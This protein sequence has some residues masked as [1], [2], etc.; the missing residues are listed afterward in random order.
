MTTG[1]KFHVSSFSMHSG[2][3]RYACDFYDLVLSSRGYER[4]DVSSGETSGIELIRPYDTV[5]IE[6][7][8]NQDAE[9]RFLYEL[10][11]RRHQFIDL[12]LHD[13]PFIRWPHFGFKN[14]LL[15]RLSKF[16][17]LYLANFGF[18]QQ[19][20]HRIRRIFALTRKGHDIVR[21]RYGLSSVY[22]LPFVL[23]TGEIQDP[24]PLVPNLFFFGFIAENKGLEYA[25]ALHEVIL[26]DF[27]ACRFLV[28]GDSTN[29]T[30]TRYL[31]KLKHRYSRNVDYLGFVEESELAAAFQR[32]SIALLPFEPYRS[33]VPAS[34]SI[35]GAMKMGKVVFSRNVNAISEFVHDGKTGFFLSG[36]LPDDATMLSSVLSDS[37]R[38]H[39]VSLEAIRYLR[40]AHN[41]EVVAAAFDQASYR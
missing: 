39:Q 33:V 36:K 16:V 12:T 9:I 7:G 34:A 1:R 6:I 21:S 13:P 31:G 20:F 35:L 28:F 22:Y 8:I 40:M 24:L 10:I 37:R 5:H 27:P 23:R 2:I 25:L 11:E 15:N 32:A 19:E 26:I 17:H 4:I 18:G 14:A 41:P 29:P 3:S 38:A 30:G